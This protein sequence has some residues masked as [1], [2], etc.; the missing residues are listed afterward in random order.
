MGM[1]TATVKLQ[2]PDGK[3]SVV[4]CVGMGPIDAAYKAVD[5][6]IDVDAELV[7]YTVSA[8][9]SGIDS[10]ATTRVRLVTLHVWLSACARVVSVSSRA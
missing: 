3:V 1:P 5:S 8:V 4:S 7:D 2:A 6:V 10:V 9:S